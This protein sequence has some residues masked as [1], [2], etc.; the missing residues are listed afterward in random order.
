MAWHLSAPG[1]TMHVNV[2]ADIEARLGTRGRLH[3]IAL[4]WDDVIGSRGGWVEPRE[5]ISVGLG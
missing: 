5:A 3:L 2:S 1:T 4:A